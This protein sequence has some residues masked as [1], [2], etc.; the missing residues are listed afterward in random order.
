[1]RA[2]V[3]RVRLIDRDVVEWSNLQR[4]ILFNESHAE[5]ATPKAVAAAEQLAL[6]NSTVALEVCVRDV[7]AG[8]AEQLLK[9]VDL[10]LDGT[11]NLETRYLI[12][13]VAVRSGIPWVYSAAVATYG[14]VMPIIPGNT[15]CL[16]CLYPS[17]DSAGEATCDTVGVLGPIITVIGGIAAAEGLKILTGAHDQLRRGLTWV[18]VW[19]NTTQSTE[20]GGP[21][22]GCPAC[23]ERQFVLLDRGPR[24]LNARLCG[25]DAVQVRPSEITALDLHLL[26]TRLVAPRAR[27]PHRV[28]TSN[29]PGW[30]RA[31]YL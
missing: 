15:A 2:G 28:S 3:G 21:V 22:A 24:A 9:D 23:A 30:L 4:Q 25:R 6:A 20:L 7:H 29:K 31:L 14:L 11:D 13:E 12:N 27:H 5:L 10:V 19:F 1:M 18:D 8:N 26:E 16:R 17:M